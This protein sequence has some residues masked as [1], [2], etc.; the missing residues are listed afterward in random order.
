MGDH[1]G[2]CPECGGS[3]GKHHGDCIYDGTNGP[4]R[5]YGGPSG[6]DNAAALRLYI[7]I[8][9]CAFIGF[10]IDETFGALIMTIGCGWEF[11]KRW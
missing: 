8:I 3:N 7:I 6:N 1:G 10:A 2:N 11:L 9:I 5:S 4:G